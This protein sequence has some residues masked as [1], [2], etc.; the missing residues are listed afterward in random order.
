MR[1]FE[2]IIRKLQIKQNIVIGVRYLLLVMLLVIIV[3]NLFFV[4]FS[5]NQN[6]LRELFLFALGIKIFLALLFIYFVLQANRAMLSRYQTAKQLDEFNGDKADTYQNAL[7]LKNEQA[8]NNILERIFSVADSKVKTQQIKPDFSILDPLWKIFIIIFVVS[9]FVFF[10]NPT[11]FTE[12]YEFFSLRKMPQAQHKTFVEVQPGDLSVTRNSSITIEVLNPEPEIEHRL[13]YRIDENWREEKLYN[14]KKVFENLDF[15]FSY[16]INTPYAISDTFR[17]EVYEL[18]VV[19]NIGIRFD[20]PSYT[21][22]KPDFEPNSSGTIKALRNTD[23]TI[24]IEANNPLEKASIIFSDGTYLDMERTGKSA[25]KTRFKVVKNLDYHFNLIDILGNNS[26]KITRNITAVPDEPPEI[27]IVSP[28]KDTLITQ[29]MLL[30]LKIFA[31]DDY[32]LQNM[33]LLYSVDIEEE[34]VLNIQATLQGNS[35]NLDYIFDLTQM[36][37]IPGDKVTYWV[38]ICDNSPAKQVARSRKYIARFP[39]I[40]E[41]YREIEKAE[42]EKSEILQ[43]T[44]EESLELQKEFDEKRREL[45]KKEELDWED[46]K[47]IEKFLEKQENLNENIDQVAE[48]FQNLLEKFEDNKALSQETLEKMERI[49]ELMEDISNEQLQEALEKM[50]ES[51]EQLDP[52]VLNKAMEDF[53]FSMEDFA[54]KLEQTIQLLEDIKKEQS[55]QKALEIAE[56]MEEMQASLNEKT[57]NSE[58]SDQ[59]MAEEQQNIAD[60]LDSLQEQLDKAEDLMDEQKDS[61]LMQAMDELRE[62][63]QQDSLS[64]DLMQSMENLQQG[65]MQK[66]QQSQQSAQQK[67]QKMTQKLKQMQ[68]MMAAG[69]MME[70]GENIQKAI[71]RLL[72]F[73]QLHEESSNRFLNDPFLILPDQ[74][75]IYE[76]INLSLVELFATPMIIL[77]VGP[78]FLYDANFTSSSYRELFQYINDAKKGKVKE[79]LKDIQKGINLMIYDLM[80]AANNM[81]QGGGGSCSMQSM[82]QALQQ[83]GQQQLAMNMMTQ[84]LMMQMSQEGGLSQE[85]RAQAQRLARDEERLAENL[86]RILQNNRDAQNQTSA[87]NKII[88]DLESI[89][90]DLKRGRIDQDILDKQERILSRLLDAQKSIHKREFSKKRKAELSEI[91]DWELPEEIKLKFDK[92]RKKALLNEDYKEFPKEYQE[93]IREYLRLLNEKAE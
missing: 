57:E 18:P 4:V 32:G 43:N 29:N 73:S 93:L 1:K 66:A 69:S 49:R 44:L 17:I 65:D 39:S 23:V 37:L 40:E 11:K 71:R 27:K 77:A 86:K 67:M 47:E 38:E 50:R 75:A 9:L 33:K 26:R 82:M 59:K 16:F 46:K 83:M 35:I 14:H 70:M 41:I 8:D 53:K 15:S 25:F 61:D 91:E 31:S 36:F 79:Y 88:D 20:Y 74:I 12:M 56:E 28:G 48:D 81:Q 13:F 7:E 84:Q 34:N 2:K 87:L 5:V 58:A 54:E 62:Q 6:H 3:F 78:K 24:N 52:D 85:A 63:M 19:K 68:Q 80:Q 10:L 21:S 30:P 72:I 22:L 60:K 51:M 92:M 90:H 89:A 42:K 64:S 76:G 45:M 55:I